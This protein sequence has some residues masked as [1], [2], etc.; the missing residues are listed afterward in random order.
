MRNSV[1]EQAAGTGVLVE[2]DLELLLGSYAAAAKSS[3]NPPVSDE[4]TLQESEE[5]NITRTI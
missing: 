3:S 5:G 2:P 4:S 1:W